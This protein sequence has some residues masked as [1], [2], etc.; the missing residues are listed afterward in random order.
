MTPIGIDIFL[1]FRPF[2]LFHLS[3]IT[4]IGSLNLVISIIV[5]VIE[6]SFNLS[7]SSLA[8]KFLSIFFILAYLISF[9][10]CLSILFKFFFIKSLNFNK[11]L[12]FVF[13][14]TFSKL[15]LTEF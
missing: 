1:I 4:P 15:A 3:K 5:L 14:S 13:V 10:F 8:T 9:L 12:F 11:T 6:L 2:G 7:N